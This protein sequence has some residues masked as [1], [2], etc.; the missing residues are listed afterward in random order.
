MK[1]Q[2]LIGSTNMNTN[3]VEYRS[4]IRLQKWLNDNNMETLIVLQIHDSILLD[5][6]P[7]E[8]EA[9]VQKLQSIMREELLEE[10]GMV[11][12]EVNTPVCIVEGE[13]NE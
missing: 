5:A 1:W 2:R 12:G 7:H 11:E 10:F 3:L 13:R 9:V 4:L 8:V 6:P